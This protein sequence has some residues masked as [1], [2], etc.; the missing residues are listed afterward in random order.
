MKRSIV[1][2]LAVLLISV[3]ALGGCSSSNDPSIETPAANNSSISEEDALAVAL[4]D[5][6]IQE[7]AA[8]ELNVEATDVDGSKAY[9]I[10]FVWSGFDYQYTIDASSGEIIEALFDGEVV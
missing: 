4:E 8:E 1:I 3:F 7:S 6:G 2:L 10:S 9:V 5:A